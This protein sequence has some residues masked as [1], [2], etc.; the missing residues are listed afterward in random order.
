MN[1]ISG[2][3]HSCERKEYGFIVLREYTIIFQKKVTNK[4]WNTG[5]RYTYF[6]NHVT[7]FLLGGAL[8]EAGEGTRGGSP[9]FIWTLIP[10]RLLFFYAK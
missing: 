7:N 8:G 4:P 1:L 6:I 9:A 2:T 5:T 10:F 3:H